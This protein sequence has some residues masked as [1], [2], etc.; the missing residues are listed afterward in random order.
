M[1]MDTIEIIYDEAKFRTDTV[2]P[3]VLRTVKYNDKDYRCV[4]NKDFIEESEGIYNL[5]DNKAASIVQKKWDTFYWPLFKEKIE[6]G[7]YEYTPIH[8]KGQ[9]VF[10]VSL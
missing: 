6:N 10:L 9:K 1:N 2:F 3:G 4:T 8:K 5:S 7:G